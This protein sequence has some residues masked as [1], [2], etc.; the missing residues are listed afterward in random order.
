MMTPGIYRSVANSDHCCK[1]GR[2]A[3]KHNIATAVLEVDID[4][5]LLD[6]WLGRGEY[7]E[8]AVR[9]L[10]DW[11]NI[12]ILKK[13]YTEHGRRTIEHQIENDYEVL[14][15]EDENKKWSVEDDLER[16][17]ID[18]DELA[19]DFI[20]RS[21]LYRH[22]TQCLDAEKGRR[23]AE[24]DWEETKIEY[25]TDKAIEQVGD[26]LRSW[27]NKGE[28]PGGQE[29]DITVEFVVGCPECSTSAPISVARQRG[30]IC[31]EHLGTAEEN[32][33]VW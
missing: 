18:P 11:L 22:L 13:V 21:S 30:Y 3:D 32:E 23:E 29:A 5:A 20:S 7:P 27:H 4:K 12:K 1:V 31:E 16:D 24:T 2:I 14:T 6:R 9:P 15:G 10:A 8:T 25:A 28:L 33:D 17:G 26:A 19:D